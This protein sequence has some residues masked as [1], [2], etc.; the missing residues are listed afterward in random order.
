MLFYL[1]SWVLL[2][3]FGGVIGSAILAITKSS[4]FSHFG[5]R[6]I[7]AI[8]LGLLTM[9]TTLLA[10]SAILPL[11]PA[12]SFSILAILATAATCSKAVRQDL[13]IVLQSLTSSV[14]LSLGILA[15]IAALNSTRLV[16]A[17]DTGLYHYQLTRWLSEYG[18]IPGLALIHFRFGFSSSWFAL[19]APFDFGVFQGRIS[20]LVG[21]L[22]IFLS[23]LHFTLAVARVYQR[24]ADRADWFLVGGYALIFLVCFSWTYEVSLSPDVPTWILTLL[25]GWLM[26]FTSRSGLSRETRLRSGHSPILP[27][28]LAFGAITLKLS[29]AP[30]LVIAGL[31]YWFNSTAKWNTRLALGSAAILIA[32]PIFI[33]NVVSSGCPVYPNSLLCLDVPWG[34]GKA[35]AQLVVVDT[36]S[37]ARWGG[38]APYG[39][40]ARNWILPWVLHLDKLLLFSICGI[41]FLG[42]VATRG[43]RT[44]R[45][46]LYVVG[47]S[48]V[49]TAFVFMTVPNPRFAAGYLALYPS[50]CMAAV[51]PTLAGLVHWRSVDPRTLKSST[52]LAYLLI[53]VA[54]LLGVQGSLRE[55]RL[56]RNIEGLKDLQ[57]RT[58]SNF[59]SRLLLPP[60]LAKFPG[61]LAIIKNRRF[62][63]LKGLELTTKRSNGIEY[64]LPVNSDQCWGATLPCLPTSLEGDVHLRYPDDSFRSGF[65]RSASPFNGLTR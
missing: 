30:I 11:S 54:V 38:P 36:V 5:D 21:G 20:G 42:F 31:F 19:A 7:T 60:A 27:L 1:F 50:L 37:W 28:I 26:L 59:S 52:A 65:I 2:A 51:G 39:A 24:R 47:L 43:W 46:V 16:E 57:T 58:G 23:L 14:V 48:L 32:L 34:I 9:A 6:V 55:L 13:R 40:T 33:A 4:C 62:N 61:D 49:G 63:R 56:R 8:W 17:Y 10:F 41:C 22:A 12:I 15:V 45:S 53:G 18:T 25:V 35:G 29:A 64:R 44:N 3:V